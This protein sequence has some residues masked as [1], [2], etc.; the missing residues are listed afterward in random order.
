MKRPSNLRPFFSA[1]LTLAALLPFALHAAE[2]TTWPGQYT[3]RPWEASRL[4]AADVVGPDG[5]VYPDFTGV[6]VTGGIPDINNSTIRATY[7]VF[8]VTS[9]GAA[10]NGTTNDDDAVAVAATAARAFLNA[11]PA[12]KAILYFPAGTYVLSAPL[13]FSQSNL[14]IDGDGPAA[15][16][17]KLET[18]PTRTGALFTLSKAPAF[19]GYLTSTTFVP[20]GGNTLTLNANPAVNSFT[21]GAWVRLAPTV[22]GAGTTVSDRY[23]N[24]DN[25]VIFNDAFWHLGRILFA[26][27]TAI[28]SGAKTVTLDRTF[29]HDYFINESPQ[30][31]RVSLAENCGV[32]DLA[33]ETLAATATIDP[34][35]FEYTANSWIK[36]IKTVKAKNWPY[37]VDNSPRFE[38][39]DSQFLGTWINLQQGGGV[40]YLGWTG[41][42]TDS[43]MD[44]C[45]ASDL[46]HMAIFQA[47]NRSVIR[48]CTFT[49]KSVQSP[50]L[51]GRFPHENLVEGTTFD[52]R[53]ADGSGATRGITAY[54]SDQAN[55]LIHGANGPRNVFYNN[56]VLS[57]MGNSDFGGT[58]E[59]FIFAYNRILKTDDIEAL[60]AVMAMDRSF[61]FVVRGNIFQA[62]GTLPAITLADATCTGWSITDNKFYGTNGYLYEGDSA[63]ALAANNRFFS[64][65]T[66]PAAATTP[67]AASIYAWQ[68]ANAATARLVLAS[69]RRIVTDTGGTTE[70]TV[71][72]VKA[73]TASDLTVTLSASPAGLSVPASVTIPIGETSATFTV[74]GTNVSGEQSVTLTV[75]ASGL[76]S[77]SETITVL[78]QNLTQPNFGGVKWPVPPVGLPS[79]WNA[80]N[81]GQVTVAGTQSYTAGTDTWTLTGGGL[82]TETFHGS[83][84]RSGRRFVYRTLDG[85][86]EIRARITAASGEQQV[87]LMIADD[88]AA[89]TDFFWVEPNG[90]VYS[91]SNDAMSGLGN[92]VVDELV[93]AGTRIV[94]CWLRLKRAG[95]VFTAYRSSVTNPATEGDWTVLATID[96]YKN[97]VTG[98]LNYKSP[99]ILDQRMHYGFFINSGSATVAASA[100]FTGTQFTGAIV[101]TIQPPAAPTGLTSTLSGNTQ[102]NLAWIDNASDETG[103]AIEVLVGSATTWNPLAT[104]AA[105]TT[106]YSH[107]G[108]LDGITYSYRVRTLRASDNASSAYTPP[109]TVTTTTTSAPLA[110]ASPA[111]QGLS[112]DE[113]QFTWSD[114]SQNETTYQIERSTSAASGFT[115]LT[116]LGVDATGYI[117]AGLADGARFYYRVRAVNSIGNSA[118][119]TPVAGA[120]LLLTPANLSVETTSETDIALSWTDNATSE[121]GYVIERSTT[122]DTGFSPVGAT[123]ANATTFTDTT[124]V[125]GTEYYYRI[126]A[127]NTYNQ[128]DYTAQVSATANNY[129]PAEFYEPFNQALSPTSLVGRPGSGSGSTGNWTLITGTP[130]ADSLLAGSLSAGRIPGLG[131]QL[132]LSETSNN[133]R[134][135]L[136]LNPAA[137]D[138]V[139]PAS[140][141][142]RTFWVSFLVRTPGT[143]ADF[144]PNLALATSNGTQVL[145][146]FA[147]TGNNNGRYSLGGDGLT[148]VDSANNSIAANTSYYYLA[149]VTV[150]DTNANAAN[151]LELI[152]ARLW[153][154]ASGTLPPLTEP[155]TDGI[156]RSVTA[157]SSR[158]ISRLDITGGSASASSRFIFDEIR[159]GASYAQVA[160]PPPPSGPG[161][162]V[163]SN[164]TNT[165]ATLTW[166]DNATDETSYKVQRAT[167]SGGPYTDIASLAANSTTYD[168]SALSPDTVYYYRIRASSSFGDSAPGTGAFTTAGYTISGTILSSGLGLSGVTVSDG[169]RSTA[170]TANG[171]YT[172]TNV[173]AG[174]FTLTPTL[175]GY[176]FTPASL[177]V[178]VATLNLTNQDFTAA[179]PVPVVTPAQSATGAIGSSFSYRIL[180][181]NSPTSY[182]LASG[183][184]PPGITLNTA[185]GLLS[186][187]PTTAGAFT[188]VVTATNAGGTSASA[189]LTITI[190]SP[191]LIVYDSFNYTL[192][193]ANPDPDAG[194]NGGNGLPAVN[195]GGN[196]SGTSTGLRG[197]NTT[198]S[199]GWGTDHT[200]VAGL[201]YSDANGV[202]ATSG[203]ALQR[204]SGTGFSATTVS[205]YRS[206]ATDPFASFR[207]AASTNFFGWNGTS[208]TTLFFS[209]LLRVNAL[210]TGTDNRLVVNLGT[211][212]SSWNVYLGQFTGTSQWRYGDQA[213]A[214]VVL[215]TAVA[216]QP[217][218]IVGRL[219]FN[220][221]TQF[222]TDFW[223][224][225]PLG[226]TLGTPTFS[227][228]YTTTTSGGQFRGLQTRD[229]TNVLTVDEFRLGTTYAAVT[230]PA[231]PPP[232]P[233]GLTATANSSSQ[234][235]LSW[236]DTASDE[237]GF[238]LERSPNGST[239]WTLIATPAANAT[240]TTDNG[241]SAGT[242]YFYRLR[243]TNTNGDSAYSNTASATILTGLQSFRLA[244]GLLT[245][246]SQDT[247]TPASDGVPNLLKYAFNMLGSGTGQASTLAT[248]NAASL[249]PAGTAGLPY[250]SIGS[251]ADTGKLQLTYIRRKP[252]ASPGVTYSVEFSDTLATWAANPSA[253]ESA[254]SLDAT[255]E[256]VTVTDSLASP[257]RRFVR[258]R[259]IASP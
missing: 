159:I 232:P 1:L 69:D 88:E 257:A 28:N 246:G 105:D 77:D 233:S 107:T 207:S 99:A 51:H 60:P 103:Y 80:G 209:V 44:N 6:G 106:A 139:N 127:I 90:R 136:A 177:S 17:I 61:D 190:G 183:S 229:G 238:K 154:Y 4:T 94:P 75:S 76:L 239:A 66:T 220:S 230:P 95:S 42:S 170:T 130:P 33:I 192:A 248:P 115:L 68:K 118:Y 153:K 119:T 73:S 34:I 215:G 224:N 67:E 219:S 171:T 143:F 37:F 98:E 231:I 142:N 7:T 121:T 241:L 122:S 55:S 125:A 181:S 135:S 212:N 188:P 206:M 71:V 134:L 47:S 89:L 205:I 227:K 179:P 250:V 22:S 245:D 53:R 191:A 195:L 211:D 101:G 48:N 132:R 199:T 59:G 82:R 19:S 172:L 150:T 57:G 109:A 252:S 29:T 45:Q 91:S 85:D 204:S 221:S 116:T 244:Y 92:G 149:K 194:A 196:P 63:P 151:G 214:N 123:A 96:L 81:Y 200:V 242:T 11:N 36:N 133:S 189:T 253:T 203:N 174:T 138:V 117:D 9:Y 97:P 111:A 213:G 2:L 5:I 202:L 251:G 3:I 100:T 160:L 182:A 102:A 137:L 254:N 141:S 124:V 155:S 12:N 79:G 140:R 255:F 43:L 56:R 167:S 16:I 126:R 240:S 236:T 259:V 84:A 108:L 164:V 152:E 110:P 70:L 10:A 14:V 93:P 13:V 23:S 65:A 147:H 87:G 78:D 114:V 176:L 243:A 228:T 52:T 223:F 201:A 24:P 157:V 21:V 20:R 64:S 258:V 54:G 41:F 235:T 225:P 165:S 72:R 234:I 104:V 237:A 173:P 249:A 168:D 144:T 50:Q 218:L 185:T 18:D 226:Q 38:V 128:S 62:I 86:G 163:F 15:S 40:A 178:T 145:T 180:A 222:V 120:T 197:A 26:K 32:Q 156:Y 175:S 46:R 74:T 187:S 113:I 83:L 162:P 31:R 129:I 158:L 208:P 184:L 30:L 256:R 217:A 27:V 39:R 131:N 49:G 186:G 198:T 146:L 112:T 216:N 148:Q 169:T 161:N 25:H 8:D 166:T 35:K 193:V 58:S 210:N 247:A